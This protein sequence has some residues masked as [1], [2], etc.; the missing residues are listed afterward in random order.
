MFRAI[1]SLFYAQKR[2]KFLVAMQW[3]KRGQKKPLKARGL[4]ASIL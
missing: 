4:L 1:D 3:V 2:S